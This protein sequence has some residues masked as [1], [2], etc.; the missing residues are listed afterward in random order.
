MV[1]RSTVWLPDRLGSDRG[2]RANQLRAQSRGP[3]NC[4]LNIDHTSAHGERCTHV[5]NTRWATG[6]GDEGMLRSAHVSHNLN[7]R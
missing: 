5:G 3:L 2:R 7:Y 1:D 6:G 4:Q